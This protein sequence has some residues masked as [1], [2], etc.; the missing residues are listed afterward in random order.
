MTTY[1]KP[2]L[3]DDDLVELTGAR[4]AAGQIRWLQQNRVAF[5]LDRAGKPKT[6]WGLV[7]KALS[8]GSSEDAY[9]SPSKPAP[10]EARSL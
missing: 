2:L 5:T 7:E 3:D 9:T 10:A 8:G 4:Q 6:T 1:T